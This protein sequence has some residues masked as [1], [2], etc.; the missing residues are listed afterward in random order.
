M[1]GRTPNYPDHDVLKD[2]QSRYVDTDKLDWIESWPGVRVKILYQDDEAKEA[3]VLYDVAPGGSLPEHIHTGI[4]N[5]FVI[6]GSLEDDLGACTAGNFVWRPVGSR[7]RRGAPMAADHHVQGSRQGPRDRGTVSQ[8]Q[9]LAPSASG[10]L[11]LRGAAAA[12]AAPGT[13]HR[14]WEPPT[15]DPPPRRDASDEPVRRAAGAID[16]RV[17]LESLGVRHELG[18]DGAR[19]PYPGSY[20]EQSGQAQSDLGFGHDR[21]ARRGAGGGRSRHRG[22]RRDPH[23]RRQRVFQRRRSCEDG[24]R[25]R[26]ARRASRR[27]AQ[28][29]SCHHPAPAADFSIARGSGHRGGQ[30]PRDRRGVRSRVHVRYPDRRRHRA[31]R[32]EL[33]ACRPRARRRRGHGCSSASSAFRRRP[34]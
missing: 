34:R 22:T 27:D 9:G 19:R 8:V 6:E 7:M 28:D 24:A 5:T 12:L 13:P 1:T 32:R 11:S 31:L 23:R 16:V 20:P 14:A 30:W 4:E 2:R 26:P 25:R 18:A 3:T 17:V 10:R 29:L 21:P 33:R 15:D